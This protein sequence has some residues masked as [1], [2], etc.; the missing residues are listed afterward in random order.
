LALSKGYL[1]AI[2]DPKL[3][4]PATAGIIDKAHCG[5]DQHFPLDWSGLRSRHNEDE[6]GSNLAVRARVVVVINGTARVRRGFFRQRER[7]YP[8]SNGVL[9]PPECREKITNFGHDVVCWNALSGGNPSGLSS[10][11]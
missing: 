10:G 5:A 1:Q 8:L 4:G 6:F 3:E 11:R 2:S 7:W 9:P